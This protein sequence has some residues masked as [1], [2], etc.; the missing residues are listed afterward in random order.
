MNSDNFFDFLKR[1][2]A[3]TRFS[4]QNPLF[5]LL[6]NHVSH[7]SLEAITFARANGIH[8]LSFPPHCSHRL[9]PLDVSVFGPWRKAANGLCKDWVDSH[10]GRVMTIRDMA[11]IF[12][13]SLRRGV[14]ES[15]I[16][17]GFIA[18][19]LWPLDQNKFTDLD[20]MPSNP[21][22]RPYT[23]DEMITDDLI[24]VAANIEYEE[25]NEDDWL[26]LRPGGPVEPSTPG[27]A[28]SLEDF[29]LLY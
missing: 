2:Q 1:F 3:F 9:Q 8:M 7:C 6:D 5:L 29:C 16:I 18:P 14:T 27:S 24:P 22:D 25:E 26:E 17:S 12:N 15:N 20:F 21:T 11:P 19:G 10:P 28:S 13:E 4:T 23:P